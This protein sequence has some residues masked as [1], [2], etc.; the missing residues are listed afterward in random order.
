MCGRKI[1]VQDQDQCVWK[2]CARAEKWQES[3]GKK[4]QDSIVNSMCLHVYGYFL[5]VSAFQQRKRSKKKEIVG[6]V[7]RISV[8]WY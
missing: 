3:A 2:C 8:G 4:D 1:K 6:V 7:V 5:S